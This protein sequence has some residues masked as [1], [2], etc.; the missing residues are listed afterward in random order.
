MKIL[1]IN[2]HTSNHGDEAAITALIDRLQLDFNFFLDVIYNIYEFNKDDDFLKKKYSF[3]QN[4]LCFKYGKFDKVYMIIDLLL[5]WLGLNISFLNSKLKKE[6][7]LLSSADIIIN[8]PGGVNL[9]PYKDIRYLWRLSKA[10]NIKKSNSV[11]I[12]SISFGPLDSFT[13]WDKFFRYFA[14]KALRNVTFL[15]LRDSYSQKRADLIG[16]KNEKSID[17]AFL[18]NSKLENEIQ[19]DINKF[20][21]PKDYTIFVPNELFSWH[22]N[23]NDESEKKKLIKTYV[24]ILEYLKEKGEFVVFI[25]QLFGSLNDTDFINFLIK[26][27]DL[28]N[29]KVIDSKYSSRIQQKIV[30]NS[31]LVI[32]ARYHTIIFAINNGRPFISLAYENKMTNT[33][34]LLE[35]EFQNYLLK[36]YD[37][38]LLVEKM[39]YTFSNLKKID[40]LVNQ[41]STKANL[42]TEKTYE[43]FVGRLKINK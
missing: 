41:A 19:I 14:I 11:S 42:I 21:L 31:K 8:S 10:I 39:N 28:V 6:V 27:V 9:G 15:S 37:Y 5:S 20:K 40:K 12:Y 23:Y 29:Y 35:L 7:E 1:L 30:K 18:K 13:L 33:L 24:C 22:P 2:Q 16:I 25:P 32:G 3:V 17:T 43:N 36:E 26:S 34:D 38:N 4:T